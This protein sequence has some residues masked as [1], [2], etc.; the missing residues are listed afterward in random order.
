MQ[1]KYKILVG[2]LVLLFSTPASGEDEILSSTE[3]K[4]VPPVQIRDEIYRDGKNLVISPWLEDGSKILVNLD[5]VYLVQ[6]EKNGDAI[7]YT[8]KTKSEF[9]AKGEIYIGSAP[10]YHHQQIKKGMLNLP[11]GLVTIDHT[12]GILYSFGHETEEGRVYYKEIILD[13]FFKNKK[14]SS[15]NE[16]KIHLVSYGVSAKNVD[17]LWS[18]LKTL[19]LVDKKEL[20]EQQKIED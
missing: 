15:S 2:V 17:D 18:Y 14:H 1:L 20:Q 13:D 5:E 4:I 12:E 8:I 7:F 10:Q 11:G 6:K 16:L 19:Q 3:S 9:G